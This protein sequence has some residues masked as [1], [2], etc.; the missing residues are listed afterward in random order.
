M[1]DKHPGANTDKIYDNLKF[2]IG[3]KIEQ[4]LSTEDQNKTL[5]EHYRVISK[6]RKIWFDHKN[7]IQLNLPHCNFIIF[8]VVSGEGGG[9]KR[10]D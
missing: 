7:S 10:Q 4:L 2:N 1:F 9:G 8:N 6:L 5:N 3:T